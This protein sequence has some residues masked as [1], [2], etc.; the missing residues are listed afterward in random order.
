MMICP[1]CGNIIKYDDKS[2]SICKLP[3]DKIISR[4]NLLLTK[5]ENIKLEYDKYLNNQIEVSS[6]NYISL[7]DLNLFKN[8]IIDIIKEANEK[9][10][11]MLNEYIETI[12]LKL[13][14]YNKEIK[15]YI[16]ELIP[17]EAV[18]SINE[19]EEILEQ[20]KMSNETKNVLKV[21]LEDFEEPIYRAA[22]G[23]L[24]TEYEKS[25]NYQKRFK[26]AISFNEKF[27]RVIDYEKVNDIVCGDDNNLKNDFK[28]IKIT[29]NNF[30]HPDKANDNKIKNKFK[31]EEEK[32]EFLYNALELYT[33]HQFIVN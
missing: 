4:N 23:L 14:R 13:E 19:A 25:I 8:E 6:D 16:E 5:I 30:M 1:E 2:C 33:K 18:E 3:K 21:L 7:E 20:R 22:A 15:E 10:K 28:S 31:N 17:I 27:H 24:R 26:P 32:K 29:L 11:L 12:D 9:D